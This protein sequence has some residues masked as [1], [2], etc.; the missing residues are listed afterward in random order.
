MRTRPLA[1]PALVAAAAIALTGCSTSSTSSASAADG[2]VNVVASTNVYGSLVE[3]IGGEHVTV[4]SILSNPNQ[5]PHT[6][7]AS[8][9]TQLAVSKAQLLIENGGGYDT[10]VDTLRSSAEST[11]PVIDVVKLSGLQKPGDADFNEHV[12]YSYPTMITLV[13]TIEAR[14]AKLDRADAGTFRANARTLTA[15]LQ[16][17]ESETA[18]LKAKYDGEHVMYTEPVPGYLFDAIGLDNVTPPKFSE[19]VEEGDDVAPS[20]LNQTLG[21]LASGT[22]VKLLAYNLQ[23]SSAETEQVKKA[24]AASG[25]AVIGV[26]ETLPTG[27]DY[28][29][30]QQSNIDHI[31]GA[32][33]R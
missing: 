7:E 15:K 2:T 30:W 29:S 14:L 31:E 16:G 26:T 33:S 9:R 12:F 27:R 4:T 23:A 5:D 6:F 3:S 32:L 11:A 18:A 8:A 1:V 19:A 17:L 28:V 20:A 22:S 13:A 10:F 21:L 25:V 24:A